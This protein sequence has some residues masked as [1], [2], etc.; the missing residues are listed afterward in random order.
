LESTSEFHERTYWESVALTKWGR[1]L[2]GLENRMILAASAMAGEPGLAIEIGCEGGRW[3][4]LLAS[5]GWDMICTDV[6]AESLQLCQRRLPQAECILVNASD[7]CIPCKQNTA[8]LLL[9]I[10]VDPVSSSD[11]FIGEAARV[12]A[13]GGI[14]VMTLL[15]KTSLRSVFHRFHRTGD[16]HNPKPRPP[17]KN[18]Y[19]SFKKRLLGAGF[20][21]IDEQGC[22]WCPFPR[23]S[24]SALVPFFVQLETCLG[25][26]QFPALSPWV[27]ISAQKTPFSS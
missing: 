16:G 10:E 19:G 9:C 22:C 24:N 2:T 6:S 12:L 11:W 1:Y 15:N 14:L 23:E 21:V 20:R 5:H 3:A 8:K 18:S 4:R 13:T 25:F 26:R 17:Y 27:L 7:T